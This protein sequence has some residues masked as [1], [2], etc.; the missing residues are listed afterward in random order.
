MLP[1]IL[2][3]EPASL[4]ADYSRRSLPPYLEALRIAGAEPA[5]V[6]LYGTPSRIADMLA[7]SQG[8]LLPGSKFDV[9]PQ[10]YGELRRPQ[11]ADADPARTAVDELLLQDAFNLQKPILAICYGVQALNVWRGGALI[12]DLRAELKTPVDHSPGR[13]VTEAHSICISPGAR[14]AAL[15]SAGASLEPQVNSSHHQAVKVPG[16]NL[17]ITAVCPADGVIEAVELDSSEH[18]V[19]GV[20]WHPERTFAS[21]P[22]SRALFGSFLSAAAS[23]QPRSVQTSMAR[24]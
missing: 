7:A 15:Q 1:R 6:P 12:Q 3:P 10:S 21:S 24:G 18:F 5:V 14:L 23:W 8:V 2:I 20:Q 16:D 19:V 4:D 17:V 13:N 11:C 22:W 9:D